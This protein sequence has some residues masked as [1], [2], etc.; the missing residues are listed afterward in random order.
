LFTVL[1]LLLTAR[2]ICPAG[3]ICKFAAS[4]TAAAGSIFT[5]FWS[6][7]IYHNKFIIFCNVNFAFVILF[8]I[9]LFAAAWFLKLAAEQYENE[10]EDDDESRI[11]H[12]AFAIAGIFLLWILLSEQIYLYWYCKN[13]FAT[14][15]ANWRF[16]A[17]MYMSI[18]WA[19]YGMLLMVVGFWR[20]IALLRYISLG[21][22][23][24]LL[25]KVFILD[26]S[27]IKSVYRIAA[28]LA[29]GITL[30]GV[31]YLYQYLRKKGFFDTILIEGKLKD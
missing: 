12:Y 23:G 15:I 27:A 13:K 17:N 6:A 29:T 11:F 21:L 26:T 10:D 28:F 8:V 16:L 5:V 20:K 31:S 3:K 25:L 1:I 4:I 14:E 2:P 9:G 24:L 19:I 22:F 18:M 30:V 7:Q